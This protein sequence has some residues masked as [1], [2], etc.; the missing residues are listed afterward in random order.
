MAT[1]NT[2]LAAMQ[3]KIEEA[4]NSLSPPPQYYAYPGPPDPNELREHIDARICHVSIQVKGKGN[5][6]DM[7]VPQTV[8]TQEPD[9]RIEATAPALQ[10]Q[11]GDVGVSATAYADF[12]G[13]VTPKLNLLVTINESIYVAYHTENT[14]PTLTA[15]VAALAAAINAKAE[16]AAVVTASSVGERLTLTATTPGAEGNA[17]TFGIGIGGTGMMM[18]KVRQQRDQF[19]INVYTYD[20]PS[21]ELVSDAIDVALEEAGFLVSGDE[22]PMRMLYEGRTQLDMEIRYGLYRRILHYTVEYN[23]TSSAEA[24]TVLKGIVTVLPPE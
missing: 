6:L 19:D 22:P 9:V 5:R 16:A 10:L 7:P 1:L 4:L 24:Y 17:I 3:A 21:R 15:L 12:S 18:T 13:I 23:M 14:T 2:V 8:M 20:D 11:G